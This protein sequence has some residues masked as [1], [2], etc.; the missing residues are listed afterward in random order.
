MRHCGAAANDDPWEC[1]TFANVQ[2]ISSLT[3]RRNQPMFHP[4]PA[5]VAKFA[6]AI[7]PRAGFDLS[8]KGE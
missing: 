7:R 2:A 4:G 6:Q 1:S 3:S 8:T 5:I